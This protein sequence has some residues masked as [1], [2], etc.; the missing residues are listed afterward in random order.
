MVYFEK[1]MFVRCKIYE[2][3]HATPV[4][5][6]KDVEATCFFIGWT[7]SREGSCERLC[8]EH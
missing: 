3:H 1:Q 4:H 7:S 8:D 5:S 6:P 2:I